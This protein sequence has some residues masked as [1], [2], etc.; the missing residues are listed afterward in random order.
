MKLSK[1]NVFEL[2]EGDILLSDGR[3][4][5]VKS[6]VEYTAWNR[7]CRR[8]TV[9][10]EDGRTIYG[11]LASEW[12]GCSII[13]KAEAFYTGGGIFCSVAWL[14]EDHYCA[15]DNDGE[16]DGFAIY[17]RSGED[18]E[19]GWFVNLVECKSVADMS[20]EEKKVLSL[21]RENLKKEMEGDF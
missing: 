10:N 8:I 20:E 16:W 18:S 19:E 7:P 17:D 15:I 6:I 12:Y 9:Q 14:D 13:P 2:N 21:L 4:W 3:K 1:E 5:L 11:D